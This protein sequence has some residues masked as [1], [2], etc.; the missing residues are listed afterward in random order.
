M[1]YARPMDQARSMPTAMPIEIELTVEPGC[2][3]ARVRGDVVDVPGATRYVD[4]LLDGCVH[5]QRR[6]L[7][8]DE[9]ATRH[10]EPMYSAWRVA[11]HL[12]DRG[13]TARVERVA[14]VPHDYSWILARL[15]TVMLRERGVRCRLFKSMTEARAWIEA[16]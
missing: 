7:L 1:A 8:V 12:I 2:L 10:H 13:I 16:P 4:Q 11:E 3:F 9:T 5:N 15:F 14:C 6:R